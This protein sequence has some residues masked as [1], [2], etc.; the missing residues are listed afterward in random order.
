LARFIAP[1]AERQVRRFCDG[2]LQMFTSV[3]AIAMGTPLAT[4]ASQ[5]ASLSL[6]S[7]WM[8]SMA[9]IVPYASFGIGLYT[10]VTA[11]IGGD[12]GDALGSQLARQHAEILHELDGLRAAT[13]AGFLH[14]DSRF[15]AL[16]RHLAEM[17]RGVLQGLQY[18][19]DHNRQR[20]EETQTV[21]ARLTNEFA[22]M[23]Q[24][25]GMAL[26]ELSLK[27]LREACG[28]VEEY[29]TRFGSLANMERSDF[30]SYIQ[31]IEDWLKGAVGVVP[32]LQVA[33]GSRLAL[34]FSDD[35]ISGVTT[36]SSPLLGYLV[37]YHAR[38]LPDAI[39]PPP[40][41]MPN[42]ELFGVAA[43]SYV[44]LREECPHSASYDADNKEI[45]R[46]VAVAQET[47]DY[48][49]GLRTDVDLWPAL[50]QRY[51][52]ALAKVKTFIGSYR[53]KT[54]AQA[55]SLLHGMSFPFRKSR[56]DTPSLPTWPV[57]PDNK[58][59]HEV[60]KHG[61]ALAQ[62]IADGLKYGDVHP[63]GGRPLL[64]RSNR[65]P[66]RRQV[67]FVRME[68]RATELLDE[69]TPAGKLLDALLHDLNAARGMILAFC[70][71]AHLP[72]SIEDWNNRP[73]RHSIRQHL[74]EMTEGRG[75]FGILDGCAPTNQH[76]GHLRETGCYPIE[77]R[78]PE[79]G[80]EDNTEVRA[81]VSTVPNPLVTELSFHVAQLSRVALS[82][83]PEPPPPPAAQVE[84]AQQ[85]AAL[86]ATATQQSGQIADL[87]T[88]VTQQNEQIAESNVR[89]GQ[90]AAEVESLRSISRRREV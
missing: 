21:L 12:D 53:W 67:A 15:D 40:G 80:F 33:N 37:Q 44:K 24:L 18:I 23:L 79:R 75:M 42:I 86:V 19:E 52:L 74:Q 14:M 9:P 50:V 34:N 71:A 48:L 78:H 49:N 46:I 84:Q 43:R 57:L 82:P 16:D 88:I 85:I 69:K 28:R 7:P 66:L 73:S 83:R 13:M 76:F 54:E 65:H 47:I 56:K 90:L 72:N 68:Q 59:L 5:T 64:E 55:L 4:V 38:L 70:Q 2:G 62:P 81:F 63:S 36:P 22:R 17:G 10:C 89:M 87:L 77:L 35:E 61:Q 30:K 29:T 3:H 20:H 60:F 58:A 41:D 11:F 45:P 8:A 25:I 51:D 27:E 39:L 6:F 1:R 31:V 32:H 26:N